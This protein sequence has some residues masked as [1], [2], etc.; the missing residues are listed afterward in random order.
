MESIV[1]NLTRVSDGEVISD[2]EYLMKYCID[3]EWYQ[4]PLL[5]LNKGKQHRQWTIYINGDQWNTLYGVVGGKLLQAAGKGE[6]KNVGRS[7]EKSTTQDCLRIIRTKWD[8]Q[9]RK[10]GYTLSDVDVKYQWPLCPMLGVSMDSVLGKKTLFNWDQELIIQDKLDGHRCLI[11][12]REGKIFLH[13][14]GRIEYEFMGHIKE[15]MKKVFEGINDEMHES[16]IFDGEVYM[17]QSGLR[18]DIASIVRRTVNEKDSTG[19]IFYIYDI[20]Y[21]PDYSL[22]YIDRLGLLQSLIP[23]DMANI[24]IL[25]FEIISGEKKIND[26]LLKSKEDGYEGIMVKFKNMIYEPGKRSAGMIKFKLEMNID[27]LIIGFASGKNSHEGSVSFEC[28]MPDG[29]TKFTCVPAATDLQ[30]RQMYENGDDYVGRMCVVR[31]FCIGPNKC[32]QFHN[33]VEIKEKPVPLLETIVK[34]EN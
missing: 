32:P 17:H 1:N 2:D 20:I 15:Q 11:S 18:E 5:Y 25:P 23:E 16:I 4:L 33:I 12:K 26:R 31:C 34:T 3:G 10:N 22:T 21:T 28:L 14:R 19:V 24:K 9:Q 27:C 30:K 29:L 6:M 7:N 13:T 8:D